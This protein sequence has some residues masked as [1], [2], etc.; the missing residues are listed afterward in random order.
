MS[1]PS[2]ELW[3]VVARWQ[4]QTDDGSIT[5]YLAGL[6]ADRGFWGYVH[7]RTQSQQENRSFE[8]TFEAETFE[9]AANLIQVISRDQEITRYVEGETRPKQ[10]DGLVGIG[11]RSA[12]RKIFC[13]QDGVAEPDHPSVVRVYGELIALI[14]PTLL[15]NII[16]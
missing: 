11:S 16:Q 13:L 9:Q 12:F 2:S 14:Q 7:F 8:G 1:E 4:Q 3:P 6:R 15:A 5:W 10:W